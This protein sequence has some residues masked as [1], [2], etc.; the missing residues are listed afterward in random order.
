MRGRSAPFDVIDVA[1]VVGSEPSG[2][3]A[4]G[5]GG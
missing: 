5:C 2:G 3:R 1:V 4:V